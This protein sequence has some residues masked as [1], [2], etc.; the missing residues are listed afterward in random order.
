MH[1]RY[2]RSVRIE[3]LGETRRTGLSRAVL[4]VS[5]P[6]LSLL[7]PALAV[8]VADTGGRSEP[9]RVCADVE[10][11]LLYYSGV[12]ALVALT[13]AVG[14]GLLAADRIMMTPGLRIVSQAAHR[15]IS[16]V[17]ISALANHI[18][19]EILAHRVRL[20]DGF[21]PFLAD[22]RTFFMGLGTLA[23]DLFIVVIISGVLRARFASGQRRALWRALH[24]LAYAAWLLGILHGLLAGRSAKPYVDW[25]Y[26]CC[27]AL[28]G[29]ALILRVVLDSRGRRSPAGPP[30]RGTAPLPVRSPALPGYAQR[31]GWTVARIDDGEQG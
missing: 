6:A 3:H 18:M 7:L 23:S 31:P 21:V 14:A 19:L 27:V 22:R 20:I 16:L 9:V 24:S 28:V 15:M 13:A 11:F 29:M 17:G 8:A 30:S 2:R 26:G 1:R 12:F 5:I 4:I 10:R 25:S